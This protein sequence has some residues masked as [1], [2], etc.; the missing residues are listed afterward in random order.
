MPGPR[1]YEPQCEAEG[2]SL[3]CFQH[4]ELKLTPRWAHGFLK[5]HKDEG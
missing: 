2:T 4:L 5:R 1:Q 3:D